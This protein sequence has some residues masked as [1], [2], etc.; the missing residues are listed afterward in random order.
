MLGRD[1]NTWLQHQ[2]TAPPPLQ[3]IYDSF[4]EYMYEEM[5]QCYLNCLD[6]AAIIAG[7]VVLE[8]LMKSNSYLKWFIVNGSQE[9]NVDLW[10]N[11]DKKKFG[12]SINYA[13]A[14]GIISKKL[15]KQLH[16]FR[17]DVRNDYLHGST[18]AIVKKS[19]WR[20]VGWLNVKTGE[21]KIDDIPLD[22]AIHLQRIAR[23]KV[24]QDLALKVM[25]FV[26]KVIVKVQNKID[27]TKIILKLIEIMR[28]IQKKKAE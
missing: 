6:H 1:R 17:E 20:N 22:K 3:N 2:R 12:D 27:T 18:P 16:L 11:I 13:C 5:R 19:T 24:D 4:T 8:A 23:I 14:V 25:I 28:D 26:H 7:C 9:H 10:N 21:S 15:K